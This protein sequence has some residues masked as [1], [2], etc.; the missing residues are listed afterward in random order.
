MGLTDTEHPPAAGIALGMA[1]RPWEISVF[2]YIL[3]AVLIL[4][5][6]RF[7]FYKVIKEI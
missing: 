1:A 2:V 5:L 7:A 4:A 6:I 3:I